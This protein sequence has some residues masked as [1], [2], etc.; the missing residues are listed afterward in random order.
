MQL[1]KVVSQDYLSGISCELDVKIED[2]FDHQT[3]IWGSFH[4]SYAR[5]FMYDTSQCYKDKN[6]SNI[7][8]NK[9]GILLKNICS[10]RY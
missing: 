8:Y 7:D 9:K 4:E 10:C 1:Q 5:K 6:F 3:F 2:I